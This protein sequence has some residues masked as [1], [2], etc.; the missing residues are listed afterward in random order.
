[1]KKSAVFEINTVVE[2]VYGSRQRVRLLRR[3]AVGKVY[4]S[5]KE[6]R[7]LLRCKI[8]PKKYGG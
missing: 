2:E 4:G 3:Y 8:V 6:V 1:M 7:L 5:R